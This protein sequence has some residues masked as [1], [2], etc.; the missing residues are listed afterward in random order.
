MIHP[1]EHP[2]HRSDGARQNRQGATENP[3]N[4]DKSDHRRLTATD[5]FPFTL[6]RSGVRVPQRSIVV[7]FTTLH[8]FMPRQFDS[9]TAFM[10]A[11]ARELICGSLGRLG[12]LSNSRPSRRSTYRVRPTQEQG[13][14]GGS[15][16]ESARRQG[17]Y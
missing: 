16:S 9:V 13:D 6:S 11:L 7:E 10:K 12:F 1:S 15:S 14:I 8:V 5:R 17:R 4:I 3:V 2:S